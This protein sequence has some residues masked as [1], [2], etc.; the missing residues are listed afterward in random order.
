MVAI[1]RTG[2]RSMNP[3]MSND[4][5]MK[6]QLY[7]NW[8]KQYTNHELHGEHQKPAGADGD[9]FL[10]T[11]WHYRF[12]VCMG[13]EHGVLEETYWPAFIERERDSEIAYYPERSNNTLF[14]KPYSK[15]KSN[16]ASIYK[17]AVTCY[18]HQAHILCAAGLRALLEGICQDKR[19]RGRNLEVKIDGLQ[20]HLPNKNIIRNLHQF[21]FMGNKAVH[22]LATPKAEEVALAVSVIEDLL[23][24]FYELDYKA[25]QL[26]ELRRAK[27]TKARMVKKP[28][29]SLNHWTDAVDV[30]PEP[31][32]DPPKNKTA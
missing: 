17:E 12:W 30:V 9:L 24:F 1:Y 32:T 10:D 27:K 28:T 16:L 3:E 6:T 20:A 22:E 31:A 4:A 21:R 7:C 26:R 2:S 25:S 23:N 11:V 29:D 13:C 8:C 18:N 5:M 19:V 14:P 15:L